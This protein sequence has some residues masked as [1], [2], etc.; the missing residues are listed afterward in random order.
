MVV[1]VCVVGG[2]KSIR[3]LRLCAK[4]FSRETYAK[5]LQADISALSISPCSKLPYLAPSL[6]G[7]VCKHLL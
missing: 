4:K 6:L 1:K 3:R 2:K 5:L 7:S